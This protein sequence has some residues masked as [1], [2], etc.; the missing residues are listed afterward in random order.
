MIIGQN[1]GQYG[2]DAII[3]RVSTARYQA[4]GDQKALDLLRRISPAVW[5]H[6]HFLGHYAFRDKGPQLTWRSSWPE[7]TGSRVPIWHVG[8]IPPVWAQNP[9][10]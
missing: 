5:Q 6:I 4:N 2:A 10:F 8:Q 1:N 7:L 3:A 9:D